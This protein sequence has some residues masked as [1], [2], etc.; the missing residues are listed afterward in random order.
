MT[1]LHIAVSGLALSAGSAQ[2]AT[3]PWIE[4]FVRRLV[5][6]GV[7]ISPTDDTPR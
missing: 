1:K 3:A 2:A 5:Y 7:K 6:S 4:D